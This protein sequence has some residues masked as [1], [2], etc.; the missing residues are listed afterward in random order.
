MS[1]VGG[2]RYPA[3]NLL[4]AVA[5][6]LLLYAAIWG[7]YL[8]GAVLR[9]T[10]L[11]LIRGFRTRSEDAGLAVAGLPPIDL[12]IKALCIMRG[13]AFWLEAHKW[14]LGERHNRWQTSRRWEV[15][16]PTHS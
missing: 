11:R 2:P 6:A 4:V 1:N 8:K 5:K 9:L 7:L 14:L 16:L 15:I 12:K 10:A 3:R 13:G